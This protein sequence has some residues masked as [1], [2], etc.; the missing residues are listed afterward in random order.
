MTRA[1]ELGA[2]R[3]A[4]VGDV[5][6]GVD[7][8]R[9]LGDP[10]L[11]AAEADLLLLAGDLTRRGTPAE[12]AVLAREL[13]GSPVPVVAVL[14]NHDFESDAAAEIVAVLEQ[15]GVRVLDG[16]ATTV[17]V[18]GVQVGVAGTPGFGGGFR[19]ASASEFGEPLMK[20]FVHH[21]RQMADALCRSLQGL[22][23]PVRIAMTHYSPIEA[24]L[25]GERL[26]IFPFLGSYLLAEAIDT[27]GAHLA[28]HGHAHRGARAG[29]TPCGV[30]VRNVAQPLLG[31]PFT[32]LRLNAG[33]LDEEL[34]T[35]SP[36]PGG[37]ED[38]RR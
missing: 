24:T 21:T 32:V 10:G 19:G 34:A 15:A 12:A 17:D 18:D 7:S 36:A 4:A 2:V 5:H 9:V 33:E 28:I 1:P 6:V 20:A 25:R 8:E 31:R 27:G 11:L 38:E 16:T 37:R 30:P 26:E 23:T 14:G 29:V 22:D 3:I 13:L 35:S